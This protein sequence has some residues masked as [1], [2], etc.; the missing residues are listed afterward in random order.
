[1]GARYRQIHSGAGHDAQYITA[2]GPAG[3]VFVP[4]RDGRNHC[5]EEFTSI[6]DIE[7]GANTLLLTT[8]DLAGPYSAGGSA[9]PTT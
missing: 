7:V 4:T 6:D 8:L 1:M 5:E 9:S 3:I 2:I